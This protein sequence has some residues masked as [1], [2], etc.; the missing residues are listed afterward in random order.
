MASSKQ[1]Q[2]SYVPTDESDTY[3]ELD[4]K[5]L[6]DT[7]RHLR[8]IF[9]MLDILVTH[10]AE[11]PD[12]YVWS[13]MMMY[14]EKGNPRAFVKPDIFV[15]FGIGKQERRI[16]KVWEEGKPP[17]FIMEF[18]SRSTYDNDLGGKKEIYAAMG[19]AEYFLYDPFRSCLP[20]PLMGFRLFDGDYVD[21]LPL[22]NGGVPSETLNL[23]FLL[24]DDDIGVYETV[25]GRWLKTR[26]EQEADARHQEVI[27]R[28]NAEAH[29]QR[30]ANARRDAEARAQRE[31]DDRRDA[32]AELAEL[33]ERLKR[34]EAKST[35]S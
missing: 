32:E 8:E 29:A 12:V 6:A 9:R 16:Y 20:A 22:A 10:F 5:P 3:P 27:A 23:E 31:A 17:D 33:R 15:S 25:A 4:G 18:A 14:Y 7:E 35:N 21:I 2:I 13:N 24:Q 28:Q 11:I 34:L 26:A 30:E 1:Y 19:V